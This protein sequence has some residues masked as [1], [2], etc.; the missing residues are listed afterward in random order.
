MKTYTYIK[1]Y[2]NE[3]VE[4][5][6]LI[7][8]SIVA[9]ANEK[10]ILSFHLDS[11]GD[12]VIDTY[13]FY[14][15]KTKV[16]GTNGSPWD[17][18]EFTNEDDEWTDHNSIEDFGFDSNQIATAF[19]NMRSEFIKIYLNEASQN[20]LLYEAAVPFEKRDIF[21]IDGNSENLVFE[22]GDKNIISIYET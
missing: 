21:K 1:A 16:S 22:S 18:D 3:T 4:T 17:F 11:D 12:G 10:Y 5:D 9:Q 15:I 6:F 14:D 13:R 8:E 19:E 7:C 20:N 2:S